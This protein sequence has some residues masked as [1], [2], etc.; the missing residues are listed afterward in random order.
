MAKSASRKAALLESLPYRTIALL[1]EWDGTAYAGW[2]YQENAPSIQGKV[3]KALTKICGESIRLHGCSRTDA[4]VHAWGHVSHFKTRCTIPVDRLPVALNTLLPQDI[5]CRDA[6]VVK[7]DFHARFQ[8]IGKQYSY[9]I[10]NFSRPSALQQ[11]YAYHEKRPLDLQAMMLA[12]QKIEGK[13]DFICFMAAGGQAKTTVRTIYSLKLE[14]T[15]K[16]LRFIVRGDGFLYNMVRIIAGTLL[17]V[18][19]GK[20]SVADIEQI[21]RSGQ[22][23][24]AGKTL[25]ACGLFLDEV[26]YPENLFG[27]AG[28][29][30]HEFLL[31]SN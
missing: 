19:L 10:Y 12:A 4:G 13:H 2:Q 11:R 24:L 15:G 29:E 9:Y 26:T 23:S 21:L 27:T 18:G 22:R 17:Y 3:E 28:G 14:Q 25:P 7:D 30:E 8:T 20:L 16:R 31:E 1:L 5:S 6:A